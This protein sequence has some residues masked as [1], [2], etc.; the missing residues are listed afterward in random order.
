MFVY[1]CVFWRKEKNTHETKKQECLTHCINSDFGN[2]VDCTYSNWTTCSK[3]CGY[4]V[5]TRYVVT[6]QKYGGKCNGDT[7]LECHVKNCPSKPSKS[8]F[9]F[10]NSL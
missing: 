7:K 2:L 9:F 5:Q 6:P 1:I 10:N 3:T 8:N 4:G